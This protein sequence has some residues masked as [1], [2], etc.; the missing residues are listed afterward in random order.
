MAAVIMVEMVEYPLMLQQTLHEI[1][2][3][4]AILHAIVARFIGLLQP[5]LD[6]A[7]FVKPQHLFDDIHHRFLLE[8]PVVAPQ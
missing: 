5:L 1:Q 3:A 4:F 2:I 7:M 8:N 6:L